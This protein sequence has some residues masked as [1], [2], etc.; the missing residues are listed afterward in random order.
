M[1]KLKFNKVLVTLLAILVPVLALTL[2]GCGSSGS[3][4]ATNSTSATVTSSNGITA[5]QVVSST[6][7]GVATVTVPKDTALYSDAA[8]T[9]LV[10]GTIT[11]TTTALTSVSALPTAVQTGTLVASSGLVLDTIGGVAD[12]T[13]SNG[14]ST[15]KA[16]GTPIT[17]N[18][19]LASG[20]AAVGSSVSYYSVDS[21]GNWTLEGTATV[22]ADGSIDM[23]VTHL[24]LW[25]AGQ[26]KSNTSATAVS[27]TYSVL[28]SGGTSLTLVIGANGII[29][30]S[31]GDAGHTIAGTAAST[32][33]FSLTVTGSAAEGVVY[34]TGNIIPATGAISGTYYFTDPGQ[35]KTTG[36]FSGTRL[37]ATAVSGTYSVLAS[38]GTSLTLVIGAT[39]IISGSDGDAGHTIAGTAA[40]TGA[41]SLTV[42]GSAAEGVVYITGNIIPA[43]GAISGTYYFTDP[44]QS[45]TTGT[46]SGTRL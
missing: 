23:V 10:S 26:F 34:I 38:G 6:P 30:G 19:K 22:K 35:P 11:T 14:T 17:V 29:S 31:D 33:A 18:L 3:T 24:S 1:E 45:K 46:F 5:L 2:V 13:M 15:V 36:T 8:K 16:F 40:S 12:I 39:G 27:G 41:F 4:P 37:P 7:D 42:T 21:T 32:G 44:G 20:Y 25:G 43:T 9:Q 28:A